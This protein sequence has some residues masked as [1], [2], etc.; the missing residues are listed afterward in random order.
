MA[1][2]LVAY[3]SSTGNTAIVAEM[4][5]SHLQASGHTATIQDVAKIAPQ[6]LCEAYDAVLFGCSTWG[7]DEIEL[8][9]DFESLYDD[10]DEI[11]ATGKK[12]AVFGCGEVSYPYFCGAVDQIE[13]RLEGLNAVVITS[14]L[15]V[16]GNPQDMADDI[17]SWASDVNKAL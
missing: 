7:Y 8:Q 17:L 6:N 4:I 2:I 16:D 9:A 3:G 11:G 15:K 12:T 10:F 5:A 13:E 14:G 1:N